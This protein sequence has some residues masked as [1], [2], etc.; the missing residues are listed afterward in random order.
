MMKKQASKALALF[1]SL[2]MLLGVVPMMTFTA[3]AA[4]SEV[5]FY[6]PEALYITPTDNGGNQA[7]K[8]FLN[9]YRSESTQSWASAY[10]STGKL[11]FYCPAA[12]SVSIS[13]SGG[14]V[15][16]LT[17]SGTNKIDDTSFSMTA[18]NASGNIVTWTATYVVNGQTRTATSYSYVYKPN[19][20]PTG[21]ASE[22]ESDSYY[23]G[24]SKRYTYLGFVSV[25][26]GANTYD[27]G[28]TNGNQEAKG[29]ASMIY[30]GN[31][32]MK[33]DDNTRPHN[34]GY[35]DDSHPKTFRYHNN[36]NKNVTVESPAAN[37]FVDVSRFTNMNQ[38]PYNA[39]GNEVYNG[40]C[41]V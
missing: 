3:S 16:G 26:W 21:V 1:M 30:L 41:R 18:P 19:R 2:L 31:N 33:S 38:I 11:Y 6:V 24:F 29:P 36:D 20:V 32:G 35:F 28:S 40:K 27:T 17:T 5:Y 15:S 37:F 39:F 25:I 22:A 34:V 9:S 8:Y 12:S 14:T 23:S 13:V 4:S 7:V 10:E